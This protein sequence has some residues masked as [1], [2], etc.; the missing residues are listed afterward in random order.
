MKTAEII[1]VVKVGANKPI[2]KPIQSPPKIEY[3]NFGSIFMFYLF[4]YFID[5]VWGI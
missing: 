5:I 3:M 1:A 2:A 4:Y